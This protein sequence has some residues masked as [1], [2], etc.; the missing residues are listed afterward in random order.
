MDNE[1]L[2][3]AWK[4]LETL[5]VSL[6]RIGSF[7]AEHGRDAAMRALYAYAE[8]GLFHEVSTARAML[9]EALSKS[10]AAIE[11]RLENIAGSSSLR[12]WRPP[13]EPV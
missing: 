13:V 1:K 10:D 3:E 8:D 12:Y 5:T 2:I 4:V 9:L 6:A 11:D 7:S